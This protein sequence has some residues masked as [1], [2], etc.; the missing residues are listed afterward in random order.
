MLVA[1]TGWDE[2]DADPPPHVAKIAKAQDVLRSAFGGRSLAF[3][4]C[5]PK[6]H[7]YGPFS[8]RFVPTQSDVLFVGTV[9]RGVG[10]RGA[11][12]RRR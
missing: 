9:K 3:G 5:M 6:G 2:T 10:E 7:S 11:R 12:L 4:P 8:F 1:P